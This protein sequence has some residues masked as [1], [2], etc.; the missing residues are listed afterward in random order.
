MWNSWIWILDWFIQE[1]LS[2]IQIQDQ[3]IRAF[4]LFDAKNSLVLNIIK[5]VKNVEELN[6]PPHF[7][8]WTFSISFSADCNEHVFSISNALLIKSILTHPKKAISE[9]VPQWFR[10]PHFSIIFPVLQL[11]SDAFVLCQI[12]VHSCSSIPAASIL[13][14]LDEKCAKDRVQRHPNTHCHVDKNGRCLNFELY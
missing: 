13:K 2:W 9:A 1:N 6:R 7:N 3:P 8:L 4:F 12:G 10:R 5:N 14:L 11:K